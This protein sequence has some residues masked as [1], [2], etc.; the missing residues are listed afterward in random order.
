VVKQNTQ[1]RSNENS[2][3]PGG[4]GVGRGGS[5]SL[6]LTQQRTLAGSSR[7]PVTTFAWYE[8][9][10]VAHFDVSLHTPFLPCA[11]HGGGGGGGG[12]GLSAPR[13]TNKIERG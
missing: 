6:A 3:E 7:Q 11:M 2:N 4:F 8:N 1:S 13:R 5:T 10:C 12:S 9:D